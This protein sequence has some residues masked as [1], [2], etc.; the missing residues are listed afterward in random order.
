MEKRDII[1]NKLK[2]RLKTIFEEKN[3][4][5]PTYNTF[6]QG[7]Y[8]MGTGVIPLNSDFDIDVGVSFCIKKDDYPNPVEVKQWVLDSLDDH[9]KNVE[10]RRSC[11]TVYYHKDDEPVYHV[12]LAVYSD[13]SSN[14]DGKKYLAKG[15]QNSS[16]DNKFWEIS[17]PQKLAEAIDNKYSGDDKTQFI[18]VIRYLKRW[19]DFKFS[20]NGNASPIGIGLTISTYQWFIPQK[21]LMDA[22]ANN[23]KFNDL[24]ATKTVVNGMLSNFRY[25]QEG[26]ETTERL[27]VYLP[28]EPQSELFKNMTNNQMSNLKEK[29]NELLNALTSAAKETDPQKACK[30]LQNVF[31]DDFPVPD[32][33]D[34]A[35]KKS[36]AIATA[37]ASAHA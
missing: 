34:T 4:S 36:P 1:L 18:R 20:S 13:E 31:G 2:K 25:Y 32:K 17:E 37:S 16:D 15:K 24:Q 19:K 23:Y 33:P 22:L 30:T 6:N 11:V 9:T 10:L 7:S 12:D 8:A 28:V 21:D 5:V 3:K 29:L 14:T 35:Q 27:K 26:A